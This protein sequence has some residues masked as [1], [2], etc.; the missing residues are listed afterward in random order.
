M[1]NP[2]DD[3]LGSM[4]GGS[5]RPE[6]QRIMRATQLQALLLAH[7]FFKAQASEAAAAK[8]APV[9]Q[10]LTSKVLKDAS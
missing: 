4:G 6:L 3:L 5:S 1:S 8:L 2:I 10:R 9:I 7:Q